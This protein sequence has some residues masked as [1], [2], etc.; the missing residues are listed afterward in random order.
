[1][2][3]G[4]LTTAS[5]DQSDTEKLFKSKG[6]NALKICPLISKSQYF[7]QCELLFLKKKIR[8]NDLNYI[9]TSDHQNT[10]A[11]KWTTH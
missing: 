5:S 1:M 3:K 11:E 9:K 4:N 10:D 7:V 2:Q 8:R 6:K